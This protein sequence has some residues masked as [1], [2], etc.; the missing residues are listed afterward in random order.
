MTIGLL[1]QALVAIFARHDRAQLVD[2][3]RCPAPPQKPQLGQMRPQGV[4]KGNAGVP[5]SQNIGNVA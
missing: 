3:E 1:T 4:K 2:P 5:G